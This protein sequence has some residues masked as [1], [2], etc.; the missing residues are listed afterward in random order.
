[1]LIDSCCKWHHSSLS[2]TSV[3]GVADFYIE[4]VLSEKETCPTHLAD[5][6]INTDVRIIQKSVALTVMCVCVV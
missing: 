1:M 6:I 4:I 3:R 2:V 5:L